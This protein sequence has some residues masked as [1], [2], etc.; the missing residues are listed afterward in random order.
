MF[1]HL[2]CFFAFQSHIQSRW[3]VQCGKIKLPEAE[4]VIQCA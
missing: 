2:L 1:H 4:T 3:A